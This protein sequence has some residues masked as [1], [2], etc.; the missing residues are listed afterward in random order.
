MLKSCL[1]L[2]NSYNKFGQNEKIKYLCA[3]F[4]KNKMKKILYFITAALIA[5]A[6]SACTDTQTYAD[7]VSD[8]ESY[9]DHLVS[10]ENFNVRS[11]SDETIE[12]WT[13]QVLNDSVNPAT[14]FDLNQWYTITEGNFKRLYF[15]VNKWGTGYDRW[16]R[17]TAYQDSI[18]QNMQPRVKPDSVSFYDNKIVSGSYVLVRYDSLYLMSDT[19]D[20]HSETPV[21]NLDPYSYQLIY[22]WSESYYATTYYSYYYGSSSSYACTSGGLAFPVRFLWYDSDVSLIVPFSLVP[23]DYSSYYYTLYYGRVKYSKPNYLPE[24]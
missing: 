3:Q 18:K 9:I 23:S 20:I 24:E 13:D 22:G 15:K 5:F 10:T 17:W 11:I 7:L 2:I 8:E 21:N 6:N 19:L 1:F 4:I 12:D 14:L 16:Q